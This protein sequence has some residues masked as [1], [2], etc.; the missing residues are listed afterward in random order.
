MKIDG[1]DLLL[2]IF[3]IGGLWK[4]NWTPFMIMIALIILTAFLRKD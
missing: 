3:A 2:C 4:N 1:E